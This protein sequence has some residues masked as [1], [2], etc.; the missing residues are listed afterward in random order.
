LCPNKMQSTIHEKINHW[1]YN[2]FDKNIP[3]EGNI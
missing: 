3:E 2:K 1:Y